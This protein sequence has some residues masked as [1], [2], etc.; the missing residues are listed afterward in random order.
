MS[1][2]LPSV[3]HK[4]GKG[5]WTLGRVSMALGTA[6]EEFVR[7]V[8]AI[9]RFNMAKAQG[10]DEKAAMVAAARFVDA[11]SGRYTKAGKPAAFQGAIGET[12]G[13]FKT[14]MSVFMQ[15][16]FLAGSGAFKDPGTFARY[17]VATM[18]VSG[19]AGLP[20]VDDVDEFF[21]KNMDWSPMEALQKHLPEA[22][23]TGIASVFPAHDGPSRAEHGPVEKGG[24]ARRCA[25]RYQV[26]DGACDRSICQCHQ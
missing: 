5:E 11:T 12:V 3:G 9:A 23:V 7:G 25:G 4:F 20:F 15:N 19:L 6:T 2:V 1:E 21:T 10:M 14:Y 8:S 16:A 24:Y 22:A 13:M 26:L 18:G 17:M